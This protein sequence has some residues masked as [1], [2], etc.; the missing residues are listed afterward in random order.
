MDVFVDGVV[1]VNVGGLPAVPHPLVACFGEVGQ[2]VL[3]GVP[4]MATK[5]PVFEGRRIFVKVV[6]QEFEDVDHSRQEHS[7]GEES[8]RF[9]LLDD[10]FQFSGAVCGAAEF[11]GKDLLLFRGQA[12]YLDSLESPA[13]VDALLVEVQFRQGL[14]VFLEFLISVE[15]KLIDAAE[16]AVGEFLFGRSDVLEFAQQVRQHDVGGRNGLVDGVVVFQ[17]VVPHGADFLFQFTA[18]GIRETAEG[19]TPCVMEVSL[20]DGTLVDHQHL[21]ALGHLVCHNVCGHLHF[22][23]AG[24]C[25]DRVGAGAFVFGIHRHLVGVGIGGV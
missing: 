21:L 16:N 12:C 13:G 25:L 20:A 24:K 6:A 5:L 4:V 10:R 19:R 11:F 15:I 7:G 18:V 2:R 8:R 1:G 9:H 17:E 3:V 22:L 14:D 23:G